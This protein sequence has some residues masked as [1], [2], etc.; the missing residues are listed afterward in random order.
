M[1]PPAAPPSLVVVASLA[2]DL[3]ARAKL[4]ASDLEPAALALAKAGAEVYGDLAFLEE[5]LVGAPTH[6]YPRRA[7]ARMR[8]NVSL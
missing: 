4:G 6:S 2:A 7:G 5:Q 1:P 3:R 8:A